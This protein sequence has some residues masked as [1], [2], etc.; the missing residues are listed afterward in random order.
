MRKIHEIYKIDQ[1][2]KN[3]RVEESCAIKESIE[4]E[5]FLLLESFFKEG[6]WDFNQLSLKSSRG[7]ELRLKRFS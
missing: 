5:E 3:R 2:S 7:R 6:R 4:E 1:A